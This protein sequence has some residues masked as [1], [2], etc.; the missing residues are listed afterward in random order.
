MKMM[1]KVG[2]GGCQPPFFR[3]R[4]CYRFIYVSF[5]VRTGA[6]VH[7]VSQEGLRYAGGRKK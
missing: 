5:D 2:A 6:L 4:S 7:E 3:N 1:E